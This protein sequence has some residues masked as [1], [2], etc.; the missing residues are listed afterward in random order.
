LRGVVQ[1]V[2]RA[3]VTVEG[4]TV[5]QIGKG[6]AVLVG[7]E[8][9]DTDSDVAY[10]C[11]K[12]SGLRVFEDDEGKMNLS[13][14]EVGGQVLVIS[15]FTLIGDC[16]KGRRPS[17]IRSAPMDVA[18]KLYLEVADGLRARGLTVQTG[19]FRAEMEVELL[20]QGPVTLLLDSRKGF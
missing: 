9:G 13:L 15:Q 4:E 5:G 1:R 19:K 17:F 2:S 14:D 3:S 16:R 20:N 11:D 12:I 6:F 8:E 18:E 10:L 7:V